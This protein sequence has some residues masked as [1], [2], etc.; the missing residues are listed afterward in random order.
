ME[1]DNQAEIKYNIPKDANKY[2]DEF[3]V[4]FSDEIEPKVLF[5]SIDPRSAYDYADKITKNKRTP[6]V[7]RVTDPKKNLTSLLLSRS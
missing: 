5:S 2:I 7:F 3:I 4:F 1:N 6:I